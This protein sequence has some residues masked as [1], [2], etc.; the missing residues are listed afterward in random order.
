MHFP[1]VTRLYFFKM[2]DLE[3]KTSSQRRVKAAF[4]TLRKEIE[5]ELARTQKP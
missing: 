5:N 3:T 4:L 1:S 2:K